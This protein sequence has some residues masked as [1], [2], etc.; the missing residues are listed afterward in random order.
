M[1]G[2]EEPNRAD[3]PLRSLWLDWILI[4]AAVVA[5]IPFFAID[6]GAGQAE[7]F[8]RVGAITVLF[9][10]VLAY[11]SLTKHYIKFYNNMQRGHALQTSWNQL[12]VDYA[13]LIVSIYGTIIWAFGDKWI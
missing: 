4:F 13:T 3:V 11:R 2:L 10:G 5:P 6:K 1:A 8:H 7:W 9:A 12:M